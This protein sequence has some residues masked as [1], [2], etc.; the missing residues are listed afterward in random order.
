M[1]V[2]RRL[3]MHFDWLLFALTFSVPIIGLLVL[4][5]AGY[6]MEA[7]NVTFPFFSMEV[8]SPAA[9][10]QAVNLLAGLFA[11]LMGVLISPRFL[12]R[13]SPFVYFV[14]IALLVG[15]LLFGTVSNGSR[16]WFALGAFNVQPSELMK[17]AL[18]MMLA[19]VLAKSPPESGS[20]GLK[21]LLI[22]VFLVLLPVGLIIKQPDLGT[23]LA[24][25]GT[26]TMM[27]LFMGVH[28]RI[29]LFALVTF[30]VLMAPTS[31]TPYKPLVLDF[32][33]PYQQ[34]RVMDLF[35]PETDV[36]GS[37]WHIHQSKIAVGS[38][39]LLGKGFLRGSQTQ[40][41]FL[42]E[43]TTDFI[44]SVLAEEWGFVGSLLLLFL[45]FFLLYRILFVVSRSRDLFS[46]L[47]AFGVGAQIFFHIFVN[48]GM[49]I[50]LLPV[51]GL[52][53]PLMSYGGSSV[54]ST[55]FSLGLVLGAAMRRVQFAGGRV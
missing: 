39:Q 22:P 21:S 25:F 5:S 23:G 19:R 6:E 24:L 14:G 12:Q 55:L 2:D 9:T 18:I 44:F 17:F 51:V 34:R 26:G 40:L 54:V 1:W 13:I 15:V 50:G 37:G 7:R 3:I 36:Q 32:L 41:E 4:Y 52:P 45:Y 29:L 47:I 53:L 38:G 31:F 43:H 20:Y 30:S 27:V 49:V 42:P 10:R 8:T 46:A 16:R 11:M 35:D 33:K 48:I 28:R